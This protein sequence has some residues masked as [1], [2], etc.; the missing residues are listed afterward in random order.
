MK[1][2]MLLSTDGK[3]GHFW[4][5]SEGVFVKSHSDSPSNV[6]KG[7]NG[8]ALYYKH[9][10]KS[11]GFDVYQGSVDVKEESEVSDVLKF[12]QFRDSVLE[13]GDKLIEEFEGES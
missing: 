8:N 13:I 5:I 6:Y 1:G 11:F 7:S 4:E 3:L 12:Q 10:A 9:S 2:V